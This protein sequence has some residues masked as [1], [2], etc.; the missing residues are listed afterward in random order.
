MRRSLLPVVL[1]TTLI[2]Q[3]T[4]T[5]Y[6]QNPKPDPEQGK[7]V[8]KRIRAGSYVQYIPKEEPRGVLLLA[9]G[10]PTGDDIN[11]IP[12]LAERFVNRWVEFSEKYHLITVAPVFDA[13]NFD[14]VVGKEH[15]GG[16]RALF[17]RTVG[18]DEFVNQI[19]SQ[20][21]SRMKSW[22][23]RILLY[24]HS[25]GAQFASHYC[26]IY[27]NRVRAAVIGSCGGYA[28]PNASVRWPQ[29]M[30][31]WRTTFRWEP[32]QTPRSINVRPDPAGWAKAAMLPI[33]V[34]V[35]AQDTEP[36]K[37][38]TAHTGTTRVEYAQ[39]W[40]KDMNDYA[41]RQ[42]KEGRVVLTIVDG[43]GHDSAKLTP[44]S[45]KFLAEVMESSRPAK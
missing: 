26:V 37:P 6:V 42:R 4:S 40:V 28:F 13:E 41:K 19:V 17:G 27:P 44:A 33:M 10:M 1:V 11:N 43:V 18:A 15:G 9:H 39:Q 35:G 45:Q 38:R 36:Q 21:K 20:Y 16:Y 29:G 2:T 24:G 31:E 7:V 14:S 12:G 3:F 5:I 32:S 8:T 23:G 30:G 25:A 22:D 34:V